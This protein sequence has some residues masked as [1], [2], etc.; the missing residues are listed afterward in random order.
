MY[1]FYSDGI[2]SS[3]SSMGSSSQE[4]NYSHSIEIPEIKHDIHDD[5]SFS[6]TTPM[7]STPISPSSG[8]S[9][10]APIVVS[11]LNASKRAKMSR[12]EPPP[13]PSPQVDNK[14]YEFIDN[15]LE[16]TQEEKCTGYKKKIQNFCK[17]L[18]NMMEEIPENCFC[19]YMQESI[20][21]LQNFQA[22]SFFLVRAPTPTNLS[23]IPTVST[24]SNLPDFPTASN[25]TA[26]NATMQQ[27]H[28]L[29]QL[30][31]RRA[32]QETTSSNNINITT[33]TMIPKT[34]NMDPNEFF[35]LNT[36]TQTQPP[37]ITTAVMNRN[38]VGNT[39]ES[40]METQSQ[41]IN[42][43]YEGPGSQDALINDGQ[44]IYIS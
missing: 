30:Q 34:D 20:K 19:A 6:S 11:G 22:D 8:P 28:T 29:Q 3:K 38:F 23:D 32:L 1:F 5:D 12:T 7:S 14:V 41:E 25:P 16:R 18:G 27:L 4:S 15:I 2:Q 21:T 10:Y 17:V 37:L 35:H 9:S 33:V 36:E 39:E 31:I 26:S 24:V 44:H 43:E 40:S 42:E 13:P